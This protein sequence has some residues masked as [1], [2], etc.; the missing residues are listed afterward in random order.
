MVNN[1]VSQK[2]PNTQHGQT[3]G[4]FNSLQTVNSVNMPMSQSRERSPVSNQ[5]R[6]R[7]PSKGNVVAEIQYNHRHPCSI[8][9]AP[10]INDRYTSKSNNQQR[11]GMALPSSVGNKNCH[12]TT[13]SGVDD[14]DEIEQYYK[15]DEEE[16]DIAYG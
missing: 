10:V 4:A 11:A 5:I 13:I 9:T 16:D 14:Y 15:D 12:T 8:T 3:Q 2:S 1:F 7:R 6:Q